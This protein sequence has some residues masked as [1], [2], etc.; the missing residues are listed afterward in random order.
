MKQIALAVLMTIAAGFVGALAGFLLAL[1]VSEPL[2]AVVEPD[3]WGGEWR[4]CFSDDCLAYPWWS[5]NDHAVLA[6]RL[7]KHRWL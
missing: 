2:N 1:I 3:E 6:T 5:R 4:S 7:Q